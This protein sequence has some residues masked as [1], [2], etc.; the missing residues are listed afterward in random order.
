MAR[1]PPDNEEV[2]VSLPCSV[3][4]SSVVRCLCRCHVCGITRR[5]TPQFDFYRDADGDKL[6]CEKCLLKRHFGKEDP[7]VVILPGDSHE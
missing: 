6:Y 3:P 5:V 7:D 2:I 4:M 1:T